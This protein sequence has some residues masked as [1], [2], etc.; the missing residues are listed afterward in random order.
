[1]S[2]QVI[3]LLFLDLLLEHLF[4]SVCPSI[5]K[6]A[7]YYNRFSSCT[8]RFVLSSVSRW[9]HECVGQMLLAAAGN[10]NASKLR[11]WSEFEDDEGLSYS[12]KARRVEWID[13]SLASKL[14]S[15]VIAGYRTAEWIRTKQVRSS[16]TTQLKVAMLVIPL[17]LILCG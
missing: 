10:T 11:D 6:L 13:S 7:Y 5:L 2:Q 17:Y 16:V 3:R 1:M 12:L 8:L 14:S 4:N 9:S 15:R